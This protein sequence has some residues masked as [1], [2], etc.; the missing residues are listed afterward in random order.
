MKD[1]ISVIV[2]IYNTEAYLAEALD[3]FLAQT[4]ENFEIILID[5]GST[6]NSRAVMEEYCA[7]DSRIKPF[8]QENKGV[9]ETRNEGIRRSSGEYIVFWDSDDTIPPDALEVLHRCMAEEGADLASGI[10]REIDVLRTVEPKGARYLAEKPVVDK[11]DRNFMYTLS[12][13]NKMFRRDIIVDNE[14]FFK[15]IR[16]LEDGDYLL[17]YIEHCDKICGCE[18]LVYDIRIR[19]FWDQP[20]VTQL[21]T[22]SLFDECKDAVEHISD[23][24]RRMQEADKAQLPDA[25]EADAAALDKKADALVDTL[26]YRLASINV[27]NSFY[28]LI[29][30][31]DVDYSEHINHILQDL[32]SKI[33]D[34]KKR[35]LASNNPDLDLKKPL[36]GKAGLDAHPVLTVIIRESVGAGSINS[37]LAA[38]YAQR[39][40]GFNIYVSSKLKAYVDE[41]FSS[42]INLHWFGSLESIGIS[43][44]VRKTPAKFITVI[45]R[46]LMWEADGF[47]M[48]VA[49]L[50]KA[51]SY[52]V[53][54]GKCVFEGGEEVPKGINNMVFR[55]KKIR[56]GMKLIQRRP[57]DVFRRAASGERYKGGARVYIGNLESLK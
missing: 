31:N 9:S 30:K 42:R 5:D 50:G 14:I 6:D 22:E 48:A 46:P 19:P 37:V 34:E 1:L 32:M 4:Y 43:G 39:L 25:A 23:T 26:Y 2:P 41:Q 28:R 15:E 33:T 38:L 57:M 13:C 40:P 55:T 3:T 36:P 10:V 45:D 11:Y 27:I 12:V 44:V 52:D 51:K 49:E 18:H 35:Y 53:Y 29:W 8:F 24:I 47:R 54:A 21:G 17:R 16:F 20:S 56:T 7:K